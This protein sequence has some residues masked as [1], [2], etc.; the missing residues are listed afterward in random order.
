MEWEGGLDQS[1]LSVCC[2][3]PKNGL[4]FFLVC[5]ISRPLMQ[6]GDAHFDIIEL[7]GSEPVG[8]SVWKIVVSDALATFDAVFSERMARKKTVQQVG[9][10]SFSLL[11]FF[12]Q[13]QIRAGIIPRGIH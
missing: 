1:G 11:Q 2:T 8:F 4:F 3:A 7:A 12:K 10:C 9:L 13:S 6:V 5:L